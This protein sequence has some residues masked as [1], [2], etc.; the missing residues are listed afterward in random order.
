M[1]IGLKRR[2]AGRTRRGVRAVTLT[3]LVFLAAVIVLLATTGA[4]GRRDL[5]GHRERRGPV[6]E[7][8]RLGGHDI[9]RGRGCPLWGRA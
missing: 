2:F 6:R 3:A 7:R 4:G 1:G 9:V 5:L 8:R